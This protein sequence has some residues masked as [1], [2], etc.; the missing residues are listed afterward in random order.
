MIPRTLR[1]RCLPEAVYKDVPR[2]C[3]VA[4]KAKNS[5]CDAGEL[6]TSKL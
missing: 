6:R 2:G 4:R 5:V 3:G 1:A